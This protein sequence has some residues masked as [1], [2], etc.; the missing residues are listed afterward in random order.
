MYKYT[1]L[2]T[3]I[4]VQNY[5]SPSALLT[6]WLL[7]SSGVSEFFTPHTCAGVKWLVYL[8][9]C[10]SS[11]RNHQISTSRHLSNSK[12]Q[13]ICRSSRRIGSR[14]LRIKWH[15]LQASQIVCYRSHTHR[16][17]PL[18]IR[19]VISAHEHDWLGV[20]HVGNGCWQHMSKLHDNAVAR[21]AQGMCS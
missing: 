9:V 12:A 19:H 13:W 21:R 17:C 5:S 7:K 16:L 10:L 8:S 15:G 2:F 14:M 3:Q 20:V 1:I 18:C 4:V 11:P 6:T